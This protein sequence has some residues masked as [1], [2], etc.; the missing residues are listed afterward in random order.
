M[1]EWLKLIMTNEA[2][3]IS[4]NLLQNIFIHSKV[5]G[6]TQIRIVNQPVKM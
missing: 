3:K 6:N 5:S 4:Q 2:W 1:A